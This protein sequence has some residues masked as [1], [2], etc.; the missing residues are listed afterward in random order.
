M[1][2][3]HPTI[4]IKSHH[5]NQFLNEIEAGRLLPV[6]GQELLKTDINGN[7]MMFY[8]YISQEVMKK[9]EIETSDNKSPNSLAEV[10]YHYRHQH[11]NPDDVYHVAQ[12]IIEKDWAIPEPLLKLAE[13]THFDLFISIT[14]DDLIVRALNQKRFGSKAATKVLSYS[15]Q[16]Q[17]YDLPDGYGIDK[18]TPS[19]PTV[20]KLFGDISMKPFYA[21]T[22]EDILKTVH[23]L[24]MREKRPENLFDILRMRT[25][26]LLGCSLEN[27]LIRFFLCSAKNE[28]LFSKAVGGIIADQKTPKDG[29]LLPFLGRNCTLIWE[30]DSISFVDELHKRWVEK[31]PQT[32]STPCVNEKTDL[33]EQVF[34]SYASED[35]EAAIRIKNALQANGVQVWLDQEKLEGGDRFKEKIQEHIERCSIYMPILSNNT[36][37][38]RSRFLILEWNI[39]I[40]KSKMCLPSHPFIQPFAIDDI[41]EEDN[42]L[43]SEFKAIHW[44]RY[45]NG[46]VDQSFIKKLI[47]DLKRHQSREKR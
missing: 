26:A 19:I 7:E 14:P 20:F 15:P 10:A 3:N 40:D 2:K 38:R 41:S 33:S 17:L 13:I 45:V 24:Q 5:W 23:H 8:E 35:R 27:W 46:D 37:T 31:N 22:E 32:V 44:H 47:R 36:I 25:L 12:E 28:D 4:K 43:P 42:D 29:L 30:G 16:T 21:I 18:E 11:G 6:I 1:L 9:L 34:I 39:G